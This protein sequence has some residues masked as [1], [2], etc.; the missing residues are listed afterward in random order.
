MLL[1][2]SSGRAIHI[3]H[4]CPFGS[5][6]TLR[7]SPNT[8]R[9]AF[10]PPTTEPSALHPKRLR[11]ESGDLGVE[12]LRV[13]CGYAVYTNNEHV[14]LMRISDG[15]SWVFP[16]LPSNLGL[17]RGVG[18]TCDELFIRGHLASR[19]SE[20]LV[21]IRIDSLGPGIAPD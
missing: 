8:S 17:V 13:G 9:R 10:E 4:P 18:V 19:N 3:G 6:V 11:S 14:R 5:R 12:P 1:T 15:V 21:R 16:H 20:T 7:G 2:P